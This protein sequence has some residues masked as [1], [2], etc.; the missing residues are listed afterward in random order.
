MREAAKSK[1]ARREGAKG[2]SIFQLIFFICQ[3]R[4]REREAPDRRR[5]NGRRGMEDGT[6][7]SSSQSR[8]D[9]LEMPLNDF[10]L[11]IIKI[12]AQLPRTPAGRH[13]FSIFHLIFF[14]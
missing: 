4:E 12:S 2:Y 1:G 14:I 8:S 9:E 7:D 11:R 5:R 13:A 10:A 6:C 3:R